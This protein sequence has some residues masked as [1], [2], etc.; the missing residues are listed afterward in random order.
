[1]AWKSKSGKLFL[2][3]TPWFEETSRLGKTNL[4]DCLCHHCE[5]SQAVG[6]CTL[7]KN[8]AGGEPSSIWVCRA[9]RTNRFGQ[10]K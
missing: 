3:G 5:E 1:M 2:F 10:D 6:D 9:C 8:P 4:H 7:E